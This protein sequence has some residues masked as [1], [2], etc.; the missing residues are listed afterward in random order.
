[1]RG[2]IVKSQ[3]G[4]LDV[5]TESTIIVCRLRGRLK[6]GRRHGDITAVGDWV[7]IS[8]LPDGT[9]MIEEIEERQRVFSRMAPTARG[10][11][12]Q[13]II[14]NQDQVVLVFACAEPAP[15]LRMLDRFLIVAEQAETPVIIVFNKIDLM[16]LRRAKE[17]YDHYKPIGYEV[18]YTSAETGR[19]VKTLSKHLLGKISVL[20]GPS[21]VGKSSL[22]NTIQPGLGLAVR[23]VSKAT[24]KGKHTTVVREMFPLVGGGYVAD[25]PGLKTLALWD[26]EPEEVDGYFPE[27]RELVADCQFSNCMHLHEPDCAVKAAVES[28]RIHFERYESYMRLRLGETEY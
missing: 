27:I 3:S 18:I 17:L 16:G 14:A 24:R 11:Y 4:F 25:T 6:R 22:L 20:A 1:M 5:Q 15:R 2:L 7:Q 26:I 28:G 9:G 10:E 19:G 8:L 23:D 13:I 12:Q 21:G